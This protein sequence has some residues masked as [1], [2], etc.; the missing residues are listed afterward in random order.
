MI[1]SF[2][3]KAEAFAEHK[4]SGMN[5]FRKKNLQLLLYKPQIFQK[6]FKAPFYGI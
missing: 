4:V 1:L 6:C 5:D 3:K 2:E